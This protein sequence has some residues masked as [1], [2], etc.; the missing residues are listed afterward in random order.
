VQ[1]TDNTAR[2][3]PIGYVPSPGSIDV[4]NLSISPDQLKT[5]MEIDRDGWRKEADDMA[6]FFFQFG[7]RLPQE[8]SSQYE[9]LRNQLHSSKA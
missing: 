3:T 4:H 5:I 8:I 2:E 6:S 1:N 9:K 7:D